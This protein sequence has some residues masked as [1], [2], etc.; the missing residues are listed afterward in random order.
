VAARAHVKVGAHGAAQAR[1]DLDLLAAHVAVAGKRWRVRI[2]QVI[3]HH[4]AAVLGTPQRVKL[5][6]IALQ[7][8]ALNVSSLT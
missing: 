2:V 8:M 4:H 3:Q 6:V 1:A 5:V 7:H